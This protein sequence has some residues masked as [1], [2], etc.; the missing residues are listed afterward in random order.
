MTGV[1]VCLADVARAAH[2]RLSTE[3]W[4]FV[5]GASGDERGLAANRAALDAV[6]LVPRM[7]T[8]LTEA[9][10]STRLL[11]TAATFPVAVAPMAYQRLLHDDGELAA[12]RAARDLGVPFTISTLSSVSIEDIAGTGAALWFQLYWLRDR[13]AVLDLVRRA[14]QAGV[15]A[16]VVTVDVPIMGRRLR[17]LRAGFSL[18]PHVT[19]ANL[20][21]DPARTANPMVTVAEHTRLAFAPALSWSDLAWLRERT[22][23]PLVLKGILD[24]TDAE[25]AV[26]A[27]AAGVVV[28][29]HGGRQLA[30]AVPSVTALPWVVD[31]VDGQC[32]VLLDSGIRSGTDILRAVALGASGVL[33]GRP[34]L[35]G[36]AAGGTGGVAAV[37]EILRAELAAEMLLAG[38]GDVASAGRLATVGPP[39]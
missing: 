11:G 5:E 19:A 15:S 3:V 22:E 16:L 31:A 30:G 4:D 10:P 21:G 13:G 27:G 17:D 32:E 14:E 20:A 2:D 26:R 34:V 28:S 35:H 37:L 6:S 12:A 1:P 9:D 29:N 8:G 7:L 38:C 36:L 25:L 23:L 24:A 33:V 39:V 18:P